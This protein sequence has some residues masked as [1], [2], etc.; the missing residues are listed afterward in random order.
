MTPHNE[1]KIED[2]ENI[3]IMSGDPLRVKYIAENFLENFRLVNSVRNMFAYTGIYKGKR[4]T[5]MAHGM[6]IPSMGIY[7]Y[8]LYRFYDVEKI[9]RVG[10]CGTY[11]REIKLLDII[12]AEKA[13]TESNFAETLNN[14]TKKEVF[15]AVDLTNKI[16]ETSKEIGIDIH[17]GTILTS[18]AF[19]PYITNEKKDIER[20]QK[21]IDILGV[22]M[23]CYALFY[24][25]EMLGKQAA[26]LVSVADN[27]EIKEEISSQMREKGF[28]KMIELALE[29]IVR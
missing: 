26:C 8:E 23:E 3:V 28:S 14:D 29:S 12:L 24:I 19:S 6:G 11:K 20:I 9:I 10:S 5:V 1:A 27:Q 22:E 25:A 16:K 15:S 21:S 7:C 4:M 17:I 2:I 18:D 13:Y